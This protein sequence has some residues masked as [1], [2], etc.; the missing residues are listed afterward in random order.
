[1]FFCCKQVA[2]GFYHPSQACR[3]N[4]RACIQAYSPTKIRTKIPKVCGNSPG[5]PGDTKQQQKP[6]LPTN[7]RYYSIITP[8]MALK[9]TKTAWKKPNSRSKIRTKIPGR[10]KLHFSYPGSAGE[11]KYT[12]FIKKCY[13]QPK[14]HSKN[15]KFGMEACKLAYKPALQLRR[16][17]ARSKNIALRSCG[18]FFDHGGLIQAL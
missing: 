12:I 17:S 8:K 13:L 14:L 15:R 6:I 5:T 3:A 2:P 10:F 16:A 11:Q 7:S 1:M 9:T 18:M 4:F